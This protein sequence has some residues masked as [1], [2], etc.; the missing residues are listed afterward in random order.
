M[1]SDVY[2]QKNEKKYL[3]IFDLLAKVS[4]LVKYFLANR[5]G[6]I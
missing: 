1:V 3:Q 2:R 6:R 4:K 5:K